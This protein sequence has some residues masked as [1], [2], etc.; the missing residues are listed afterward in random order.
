MEPTPP[1]HG[2]IPDEDIEVFLQEADEHLQMMDQDIVRLET[3]PDDP[4]L[5]QQIFRS[6][7]TIK[8]SSAMLGHTRMADVAHSMENL[9]DRL[10][11]GS[12]GVTTDVVDVLLHCLDS[13]RAL[14]DEL[15]TG[16]PAAVDV[17]KIVKSVDTASE[18]AANGEASPQTEASPA[19]ST[20]GSQAV[21]ADVQERIRGL[22]AE[23]KSAFSV[24]ITVSGDTDWAA[25]RMFQTHAALR[26][27]GEVMVSW[28]SIEQIQAEHVEQ[29]MRVLVCSPV[30]DKTMESS[31]EQVEDLT[32]VTVEVW[33]PGSPQEEGTENETR[34]EGVTEESSD[35]S[36]GP[37]QSKGAGRQQT[38][39]V[40]VERLDH[41]MNTV[42][43]LVIDRTRIV[44][45]GKALDARYKDD[46]FVQALGET[47][48]HIVK[49]VDELQE[50][51][52]KMRMLPIGTVFSGF[53]RMVRDLAQSIGKKVEFIIEGQDTEIDRTVVD[54][55]RDP[56]VHLLRNAVDHGI[57]SPEER[58]AAGKPA[59]ARLRLAA[60]Q[61]QGHI[62]ITVEDDGRGMDPDRVR[63]AAVG[64]GL[65]TA[66]KASRLTDTE[67]L[68]LIFLPGASTH[69]T[70]T[71]ISGRG[72]G[73]DIVKTNIEAIN[74]FV[75]LET[76]LG[77]GTMFTLKMPLT[78]ATLQTLLVG[79]NRTS[80][81][82][83]LVHVLE[84]VR[85]KSS[86]ISTV[87]GRGVTQL[88][89]SLLPLLDLGEALGR[90]TA[91]RGP[92]DDAT[93]VVVQLRDRM[94]GLTVERLMGNEEI[95]V[96]SLGRFIGDVRGLAGAS[97]LADGGVV[98]IVDVPSLLNSY[99]SHGV[100]GAESP[101][102]LEVVSPDDKSGEES[103]G[104]MGELP[105][106]AIAG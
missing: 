73:M 46:D 9:L 72:V 43:E 27:L 69:V 63:K 66:E 58:L 20:R 17:S 82:V 104:E 5:L 36:A 67:V 90:G 19:G 79:L 80:F 78:L 62:A 50:S 81:A 87:G 6:S 100:R 15:V 39:R 56:L 29:A 101:I 16:A 53:P 1:I 40:D 75:S 77:R 94:V 37:D 97:I 22:M 8:G 49:V 61:E 70:A 54:R 85:V 99:F 30:D 33:E 89:G 21:A 3:E 42:G 60:F 28:P 18:A 44:Q 106:L 31:L 102:G 88:R 41:L 35:R 23:G 57:E 76:E 10:R 65:V 47:S 45:I 48:S 93:V 71:E 52:M 84:T 4:D 26:A 105:E 14:K 24:E 68:D 64:K 86:E 25:V 91:G 95:L 74:G 103:T 13:L 34:T 2:D 51:T 92:T 12:A 96:K 83:P 32:S 55:V 59:V 11:K 98:L 7:H 38:V